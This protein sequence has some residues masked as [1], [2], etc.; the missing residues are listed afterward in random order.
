[1]IERDHLRSLLLTKEDALLSEKVSDAPHML[2][3]KVKAQ[4]L[5]DFLLKSHPKH[6]D[7]N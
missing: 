5:G 2:P 1:L 6:G 3:P 7:D 4:L